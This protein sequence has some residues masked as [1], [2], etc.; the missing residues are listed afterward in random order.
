[1]RFPLA[2]LVVFIHCGIKDIAVSAVSVPLLHIFLQTLA[3]T[4]RIAVPCFFLISGYLFFQ[5]L[6]EWDWNTYVSKLRRRIYTLLIPYVIWNVLVFSMDLLPQIVGMAAGSIAPIEVAMFI[7]NNIIGVFWADNLYPWDFPLWF[8]RDLMVMMILSPIFYAV[9]KQTGIITILLLSIA[10]FTVNWI[11][12]PGFSIQAFLFFAIGAYFSIK[13]QSLT[14]F[15]YR[16]RNIIVAASLVALICS[17][18][19][20]ATIISA[21]AYKFYIFFGI[22]LMFVI[23]L[24]CVNRGIKPRKELVQSCF[25]LY[26][27]HAAYLIPLVGSPHVA[28]QKL[29]NV[30]ISDEGLL[31]ETTGCLLTPFIISA[32]AVVVVQ[33]LKMRLPKVARFI[34]V[35]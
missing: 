27:F 26:A 3:L 25:F 13:G 1:M 22:F 17:L 6:S 29:I 4:V 2:I 34:A 9:I 24:V 16:Y 8:V 20:S 11:D 18:F 19:G 30:L 35:A 33:F 21:H 31:E 15:C 32:I 7:S 5:H 12:I 10:F 28:V 23:S 14:T